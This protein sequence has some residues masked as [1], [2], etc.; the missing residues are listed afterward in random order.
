[1][2]PVTVNSTSDFAPVLSKEFRGIQG[3]LWCGFTLIR[4]HNMTR[5]DSQIQRTDKYSQLSPA[6]WPVLLNS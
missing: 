2:G 4:V 5:T 6:T 1:M 3:A